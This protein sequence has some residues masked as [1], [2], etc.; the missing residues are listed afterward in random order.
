MQIHHDKHHRAHRP[1]RRA[2]EGR[3]SADKAIKDVMCT[4]SGRSPRTSTASV[5]ITAA[6]A[7]IARL[8]KLMSPSGGGEPS[9]DGAAAIDAEFGTVRRLKEESGPPAPTGSAPVGPGW[10]KDAEVSRTCRPPTRQS[11]YNGITPHL[12]VDV[13]EH[14]YYLNYQDRRPDYIEAWWNVVDCDSIA[15]RFGA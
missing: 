11:R 4:T 1:C 9:G 6:A 2:L 13:W 7:S 8:W 5:A 3:E 10:C 12:G 15:Q 14:A